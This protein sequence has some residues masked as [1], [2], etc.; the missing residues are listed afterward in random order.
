VAAEPVDD[1]EVGYRDPV[2]EDRLE[3]ATEW[4][5]RLRV[6]PPPGW[7]AA[8]VLRLEGPERW[9]PPPDKAIMVEDL[10]LS[11]VAMRLPEPSLNPHPEPVP[12]LS[13]LRMLHARLL[14]EAIRFPLSAEWAEL[15]SHPAVLD[16]LAMRAGGQ[17]A[18]F[19]LAAER[20]PEEGL[21]VL[22][23]AMP[24]R[25]RALAEVAVPVAGLVTCDGPLL[26]WVTP[27]LW[28]WRENIELTTDHEEAHLDLVPLPEVSLERWTSMVF[29]R[30]PFLRDQRMLDDRRIE[31]RGVDEARLQ[32]FD[33][34][35]SGRGRSLT[36]VVTGVVGDLGFSFIMER[37]LEDHRSTPFVD[38]LE[39]LATVEVL[40]F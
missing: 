4:H 32:R 22:G 26:R 18:G 37:P 8:T 10:P 31:V 6:D 25:H 16:R 34:Q 30:A 36:T 27:H 13:R 23:S 5:S 20:T 19:S 39:L 2:L 35:P 3:D 17:L 28:A 38:P 29:S 40:P 11:L 33:W 12:L 1:V 7:A 21:V 15:D 9:S 14:P 24:G